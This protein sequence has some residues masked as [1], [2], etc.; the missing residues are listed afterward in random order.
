MPILRA[1][2]SSLDEAY[3]YPAL[4]PVNLVIN[5]TALGSRTLIGVT[6]EKVYP[7]RG[8]TVLV[9]APT[10]KGCYSTKIASRTQATGLQTY[11]IPRPGPEGHVILGG[12]FE[13][14]N[15]STLPDPT[16]A[17]RILQECYAV[18]PELSGGKGWEA[19]DVVSHNAGLRPVREGGARVELER[20]KIGD[21][22]Q[23]LV[24]TR[25]RGQGRAVGVVHAYGIGPAG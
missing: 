16:Q 5:A 9:K 18:C 11:I 3:A 25:A 10:V 12:T 20:R 23:G 2:L 22:A 19:I 13:R 24:P 1:R 8:Q 4:G 6:D 17:R 21:G 15:Y 14:G 7:A